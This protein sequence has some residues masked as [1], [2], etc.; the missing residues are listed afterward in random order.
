[1]LLNIPSIQLNIISMLSMILTFP[2][3]E[4]LYKQYD[5]LVKEEI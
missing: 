1:M 5:C 4:I 2:I 3:P